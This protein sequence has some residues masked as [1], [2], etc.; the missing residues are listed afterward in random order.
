[1]FSLL[2]KLQEEQRHLPENQLQT[3]VTIFSKLQ[4]AILLKKRKPATEKTYYIIYENNLHLTL[5][6]VSALNIKIELRKFVGRLR[7][8]MSPI[9]KYS[10]LLEGFSRGE[11][12]MELWT[13]QYTKNGSFKLVEAP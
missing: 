7:G 9:N 4:E 8:M 11:E 13:T 3:D 10:T 1:M 6:L 12:L 5:H 2:N